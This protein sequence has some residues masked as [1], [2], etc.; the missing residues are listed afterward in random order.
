MG[1]RRVGDEDLALGCAERHGD[2]R[3]V[4]D[5]VSPD[6]V[7]QVAHG[8][9]VAQIGAPLVDAVEGGEHTVGSHDVVAGCREAGAHAAAEPA[10][11]AGDDDAHVPSDRLDEKPLSRRE[12]R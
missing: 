9:L 5:R 2:A 6:S 1:E 3:Q 12:P 4:H 10:R 11:R 8:V 7:E